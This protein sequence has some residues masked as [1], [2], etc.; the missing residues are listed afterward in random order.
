MF[1]GRVRASPIGQGK[2]RSKQS[3]VHHG[4][5]EGGAQWGVDEN[6][7]TTGA[8]QR[9]QLKDQPKPRGP[10]QRLWG[11]AGTP[12]RENKS[13]YHVNISCYLTINNGH[14]YCFIKNIN[15]TAIRSITAKY[16][17]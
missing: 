12:V 8:S 1:A 13:L 7:T 3:V 5:Q 2:G 15:F 4:S 11:E 10:C 14:F 6:T 16:L 17:N 9:D